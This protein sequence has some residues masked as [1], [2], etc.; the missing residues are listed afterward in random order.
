MSI[1]DI[2]KIYQQF[3]S[4]QTDTRKLQ[5]GDLFFALK[6][7]SFNGNHFAKQ[8]LESGAAYAIADEKLP[9]TDE[10]IIQVANVLETLQ[11]LAKHHR[12]QFQIPFIAIQ[13]FIF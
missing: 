13:Y 3:P 11:Q 4:I 5:K 1:E 9:F 10:R 2:Y 8:A 6:G 7:P 12:T